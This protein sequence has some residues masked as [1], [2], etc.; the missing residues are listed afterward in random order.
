MSE[1]PIATNLTNLLSTQNTVTRLMDD[2]EDVGM[3]FLE[4][5][6]AFDVVNHRFLCAKLTTRGVPPLMV[7][8][9]KSYLADSNLQARS[10]YVVSEEAVVHCGVLQGSVV[11]PLLFSVIV[12]DLLDGL[13]LFCK[14]FAVDPRMRGKSAGVDLIQRGLDKIVA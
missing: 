9:F 2:E 14:L 7:S 4:V 6:Q 10:I 5:S 11:G 1:N 12:T 8:W 13:Q 3:C